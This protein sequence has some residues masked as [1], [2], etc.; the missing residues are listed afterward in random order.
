MEAIRKR[1]VSARA[2]VAAA[3]AITRSTGGM[4]LRWHGG[5]D[6]RRQMQLRDQV[7]ART[8]VAQLSVFSAANARLLQQDFELVVPAI[9][10][11][12]QYLADNDDKL[13]ERPSTVSYIDERCPGGGRVGISCSAAGGGAAAVNNVRQ[14][15]RQ[16]WGASFHEPISAAGENFSHRELPLEDK[17]NA[18]AAAQLANVEAAVAGLAS[19]GGLVSVP[20]FPL[21]RRVYAD[22]NGN[23]HRPSVAPAF[24]RSQRPLA[25]IESEL[26]IRY[27]QLKRLSRGAGQGQHPE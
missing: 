24:S 22:H 6:H 4:A 23:N 7:R 8:A 20:V 26:F 3:R 14:R 5:A 10:T 11:R 13:Q 2:V 27:L 18:L 9:G 21:H 16:N 12:N 19:D 1:S 17:V 25:P 15:N